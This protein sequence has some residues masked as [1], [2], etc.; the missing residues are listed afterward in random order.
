MSTVVKLISLFMSLL[1]LGSRLNA[2]PALD[3]YVAEALKNNQGIKQE[4]F[5]MDK[6]MQALNEARTLFL[7]SVSLLGSYTRAAGGRTIDIPIGDLLNPAYATLNQ[8]TQTH[9]FPQLQNASVLLNPDNFYDAKFRTSMPLVNA[10]IYYNRQ[11]KQQAITMQQ[12][13]VNV[14][15]RALVKDVKTAYYQYYQALQAIAIYKEAERLIDKNIT[16]NESLLRNGVRN[17]TALTRARTEKQKIVAA[18]SQAENNSQNARAYFNFLLNKPLD[19]DISCDS[20]FFSNASLPAEDIPGLKGVENRE[21]LQQIN[22]KSSMLQ[23]S[24]KMEQSYIVPKLSAFADLGSQGFNWTVNDKSRYYLLGINLEWNFFAWGQ[25]NYRI[26]QVQSDADAAALQYDETE[27]AFRLQATQSLN[28][29]QT[30]IANYHSAVSQKQLADK[31]YDDQL[32]AYKEGQ[33]L[34]IELLDAQNQLTTAE[35]QLSLAFAG[36]QIAL[37]ETERNLATYSVN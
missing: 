29:Y 12:A 3:S 31:Y 33:L 19:A 6:A 10:E 14:Y 11:I 21:E 27:K 23:L 32:K 25:H 36:V 35:L 17:S 37:A 28:N 20:S 16:V 1:L 8:L 24:R 22:L 4:Q 18:V 5:H 34:Y 26:R 13:Q 9:N 15:K 2:Q 30:A 7:P